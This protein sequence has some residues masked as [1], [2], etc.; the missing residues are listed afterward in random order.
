MTMSIAKA[1]ILA[2]SVVLFI[3]R[4][5]CGKEYVDAIKE[6]FVVLLTIIRLTCGKEHVDPIED[7]FKFMNIMDSVINNLFEV[8]EYIA[9]K[10]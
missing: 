6:M 3:I 9:E 10:N 4:L 5:K 1:L 7:A 2:M 8:H